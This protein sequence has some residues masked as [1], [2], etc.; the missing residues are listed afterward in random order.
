MQPSTPNPF[1][2][3]HNENYGPR[4]SFNKRRE[5]CEE[6]ASVLDSIKTFIQ[7]FVALSDFQACAVTAWIVH[8]HAMEAA[9]ATP[10]LAI[11][12]AEKQSG[13][14]RLLEVLETLVAKPWLTGRVTAAVLIRK[15]DQEGP[16]LLLDESDA[17]F[18]GDEQYSEALRGVLNTG[19][20]F[21]GKASCCV[22]KGAEQSYKDFRTFCPKAIAGIG[23]LPDTIADRSIRIRLKRATRAETIERFRHRDIG[24]EAAELNGRIAGLCSSFSDVLHTARP[25]LPDELTDRQQEAIEPLLAIADAA[26]GNW[27][28]SLRRAMVELCTE[29]RTLDG[30]VGVQL[31][32]DIRQILSARED[33]RVCSHELANAL[34]EIEGAPWAEWSK[35]G[36]PITAN[37]LARMLG[38]Y[39]IVPHTIRIAQKTAK[40]YLV[41]DF[42]DAW[43]RY[44]PPSP[45][46]QNVTAV[47][48]FISNKIEPTQNVT[49]DVDVTD[50]NPQKPAPDAACDVVTF[51]GQGNRSYTPDSEGPGVTCQA[52]GSHFGS[53]GGWRYHLKGRCVTVAEAAG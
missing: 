10:Y 23:K 28:H 34:S 12:S 16:T 53:L 40:G 17:A 33:D 14:T 22:G 26:G 1:D 31:L 13:K 2:P 30:S 52:C 32:S 7:R 49:E 19:N 21:S 18:S 46:T 8:T 15:I 25:E 24:P 6:L 42:K 29:A 43:A 36:K 48:S 35:N 4:P 50:P 47:T 44:L 5:E 41:E 51:S 45:V 9:D 20:R 3:L 38:P 39:D 11:T 27:P 37:K